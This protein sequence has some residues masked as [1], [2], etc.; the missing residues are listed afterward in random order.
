[1][2]ID[3]KVKYSDWKL[4]SSIARFVSAR[5]KAIMAYTNL[6]CAKSSAEMRKSWNTVHTY[7]RKNNQFNILTH[8]MWKCE[9][10]C[11]L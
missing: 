11:E 7:E 9:L 3:K 2:F 1:M 8:E 6:I 10:K 4:K 5:C